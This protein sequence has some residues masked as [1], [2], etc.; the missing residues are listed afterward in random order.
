MTKTALIWAA[1]GFI[2]GHLVKRLK[3]ECQSAR[4]RDPLSASK[5]GS[6]SMLMQFA[7]T[8][9]SESVGNRRHGSWDHACSVWAH[10]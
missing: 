6:D 7:L 8:L 3:R 9:S 5:R 10:Y 4:E 2:G 1:G